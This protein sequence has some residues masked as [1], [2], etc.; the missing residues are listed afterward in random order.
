MDAVGL[1]NAFDVLSENRAAAVAW[2]AARFNDNSVVC[3]A[4]ALS[5][6]EQTQFVSGGALALRRGPDLPFFPSIYNEDWLFFLALTERVKGEELEPLA[7]AGFVRQARYDPYPPRRARSEELGDVLA[8]GLMSLR[9]GGYGIFSAGRSASYWEAFLRQRREMIR[10]ISERLQRLARRREPHPDVP[11]AIVGLQAAADVHRRIQRDL[12]GWAA[13]FSAFVK[14]WEADLARWEALLTDPPLTKIQQVFD[15]A[16]RG[17][18]FAAQPAH[19]AP[20]DLSGRGSKDETHLV[21]A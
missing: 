19:C 18:V 20:G 4:A 8:E 9:H 13:Q 12:P 6:R 11:A 7:E 10:D 5:G 1:R 14:A 17:T 3:R 21:P 16:E 15:S 2:A